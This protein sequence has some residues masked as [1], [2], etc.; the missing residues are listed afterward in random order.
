MISKNIKAGK[1]ITELCHKPLDDVVV[2]KCPVS[3]VFIH[4]FEYLI[5]HPMRYLKTNNITLLET[6]AYNA[7]LIT[8]SDCCSNKRRGTFIH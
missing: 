2:V 5:N 8:F 1:C 3:S 6:V 4:S 7:H